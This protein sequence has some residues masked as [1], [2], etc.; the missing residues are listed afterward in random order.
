VD[1]MQLYLALLIATGFN[2]LLSGYLIGRILHSKQI[3]T[4]VTDSDNNVIAKTDIS[5]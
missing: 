3:V 4:V 2:L 1:N 5:T